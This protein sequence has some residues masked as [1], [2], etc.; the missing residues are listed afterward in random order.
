MAVWLA[1]MTKTV[2]FTWDL[3]DVAA[4]LIVCGCLAC[5]N[6]RLSNIL[7]TNSGRL[8]GA[9]NKVLT[10]LEDVERALIVN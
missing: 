10:K 6:L 9:F 1:V 5:E 7:A 4:A 8:L 2:A 3:S